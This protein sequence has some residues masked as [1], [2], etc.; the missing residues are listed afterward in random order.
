MMFSSSAV[1][2]QVRRK[3]NSDR[4]RPT[5][6]MKVVEIDD[7]V[8]FRLSQV[9]VYLQSPAKNIAYKSNRYGDIEKNK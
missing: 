3:L 9:Y 7:S 4:L 6:T 5:V 2:E 1:L 8:K